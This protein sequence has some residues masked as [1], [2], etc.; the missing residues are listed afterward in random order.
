MH[1]KIAINS[2]V[3]GKI[4]DNDPRWRSFNDSFVNQ[5]LS[6]I[7]IIGAIYSGHAYT[8]WCNGRRK[9]ENFV[10]GQHIAI[11]MDTKDERSRIDVLRM[12]P[13]VRA[14]GGIIHTTP[15]H[16]EQSPRARVIFLLDQPITSV[17]GYE[18]ATSFVMAQFDDHDPSCKDAS[19]FFFGA[20]KCN[21]W[22]D[23]KEFPVSHLRHYFRQWQPTIAPSIRP[24]PDHNIINMQERREAKRTEQEAKDELDR[25]AEALQR[26]DPWSVDYNRWIG[27]LAALKREFG[28]RALTVAEEWAKG[29]DGEVRR[30]WERHLKTGRAGKQTTLGTIFHLASGS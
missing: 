29:K 8:G 20:K 22:F 30:E 15:S 7:D 10:L 3:T 2:M 12:H 16:T 17:L 5:E 4:P 18:A 19:R 24:N 26:I 9:K 1:Y 6:I 28:D 13:L 11:D 25:V 14:Y 21:V 23:E 27:I